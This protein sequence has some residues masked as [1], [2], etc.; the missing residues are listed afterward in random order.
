MGIKIGILKDVLFDGDYDQYGAHYIVRGNLPT[1]NEH[2]PMMG[3]ASSSDQPI[4]TLT[5]FDRQLGRACSSA[6]PILML[7]LA[8]LLPLFPRRSINRKAI[9]YAT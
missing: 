4:R 5:F 3:R 6:Q 1:G 9:L 8:P 2:L 7:S